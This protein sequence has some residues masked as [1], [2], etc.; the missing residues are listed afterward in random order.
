MSGGIPIRAG[1]RIVGMV[2]GDTFYKNLS[3]SKH[4]LHTPPGIAFDLSTLDDA[5][6]AGARFV[7]IHETDAGRVY[8]AAISKIRAKGF[9]FDRGFGR[10][11][12]LGLP[13]WARD[14]EPMAEQLKLWTATIQREKQK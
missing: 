10:Q 7:E 13:D 5:E 14:A 8:R 12:C 9:T 3:R 1:A 6:R 11:I 2:H 4:F